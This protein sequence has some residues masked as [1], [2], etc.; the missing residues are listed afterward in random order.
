MFDLFRS[1]EKSVRILLGVLLVAVAGSMLIYLI[2]GGLGDSG[3]S[4][5]NTLAAVGSEKITTA[6]L[7]R[8]V[9]RLTRGQNLPK[10]ILAMYIPSMVTQLIEQKAMAYKAHEM[11]LRISDQELGDTIQAAFAAQMGGK[12]DMATYQGFLAQQGMTVTDFESQERE[13]MLG[14]QLET[15]ERQSIVISDAD[16]RAEYRRKNQKVGLDYIKLEGKDFVSK[17]NRDPALVK[18]YFEKNRGEFRV[19]EKRDIDLVVGENADF[20]QSAQVSTDQLRKDYQENIDSYRTPERVNVRHILI[21]TQG[22]PKEE[23]PKLKAKAED[24]LKQIKAGANFADLAKKDSEDPG[25]AVKGGE[26]GWI[27]RGQTVK[28][29]EDAAFSLKPG[30]TSGVI[31]TEYGYHIIQVEQKQDAHT[32]SFEEAEPQI[33]LQDKKDVAAENLRKAMDAAHAEILKT[34]SQAEAIAKKY[35]LR[36]FK[37]NGATNSTS[38]PEVNTQAELSTAIFATPRGG[39]TDV[40]N[41][42]AQGK[43]AFAIVTNVTPARN[44]DFTEAQND[45]LQKYVAA[46]SDRLAEQA[47]KTAVE[48]ARKG[49]SLETLAKEYGVKVQTAAPFTIDGAAEGIGPATQLTAAFE[50][51]VDGIVG[52]VT[53]QGGN[54]VCKVSQKIPADM[55][56]FASGKSAIVQSL[57]QQRVQ[58]QDP[59]F[60]DSIVTELKRRGKIKINND[61]I[62]KIITSY[63]S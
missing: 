46:E 41:M 58:E 47:A 37:V 3:A 62:S 43:D 31:E 1:R 15:L 16:A 56:Q 42:D 18:A 29:F 5:Q 22:K 14:A 17:V 28:P 8:E 59:L 49:E 34:P 52:P 55:S 23:A 33:L 38:L 32:Q 57:E 10:G 48:R 27:V 13:T 4:G 51:N 40:V 54:F 61:T 53:A 30:E 26:L 6:D 7:Q 24:L 50:S 11:G 19:P 20:V 12:F 25:S 63:Q 21:K 35:N 60:R 9:Q 39:T 36:F 45:V 44:M 2:P